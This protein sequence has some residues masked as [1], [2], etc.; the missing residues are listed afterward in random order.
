MIDDDKVTCVIFLDFSKA[1][2]TIDHGIRGLPQN[3]CSS[4]MT[5][6]M[7]SSMS[8]LVILKTVSCGVP[9]V[10]ILGPL[11]SLLF[12]NDL[13]KPATKLTYITYADDTNIFFSAQNSDDLEKT[14]NE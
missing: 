11:L 9:Q 14:I 5:S 2:D 10:S 7:S 4:F 6:S 1:F 13:P 12:I 8:K 3:W